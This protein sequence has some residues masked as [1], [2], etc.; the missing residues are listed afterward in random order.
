MDG[1]AGYGSRADRGA[2]GWH[3]ELCRLHPQSF[4]DGDQGS[5]DRLNSDPRHDQYPRC[6]VGGGLL[7]WLTVL[8]LGL[9]FFLLLWGFGFQL[10][11]WSNFTPFVAQRAHSAPLL[12]ALAG[13]TVAAFFSFGG[14]W[15]VTKV[16]G[17]VRDPGAHSA[18]SFDLR[19][20]YRDARLYSDQCGVPLSRAAGG[21]HFE[22]DFCGPGG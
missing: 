4:A 17:E 1:F 14:W 11:S 21:G 13:G 16:A 10:G 20:D 19:R 2:R 18:A 8:K 7:R 12:S 5:R 6:S 9:L 3:G 22:R 15:D